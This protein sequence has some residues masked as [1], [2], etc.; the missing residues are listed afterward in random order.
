MIFVSFV[1]NIIYIQFFGHIMELDVSIK[2][3]KDKLAA[4]KKAE[5]RLAVLHHIIEDCEIE[6][7]IKRSKMDAEYRD[8]KKLEQMSTASLYHKILGDIGTTI[9]KEKQEYLLSVLQ[10]DDV[11]NKISILEYEKKI[12]QA[13]VHKKNDLKEE[14]DR[15]IQQKSLQISTEKNHLLFDAIKGMDDKIDVIKNLKKD[16]VEADV[17]AQKLTSYLQ[18]IYKGLSEIDPWYD[19]SANQQFTSYSRLQYAKGAR[20]IVSNI[21]RLA[22]QLNTELSDISKEL[23]IRYDLSPFEDFVQSIYKAAIDGWQSSRYLEKAKSCIKEYQNITIRMRTK[24]MD[25]DLEADRQIQIIESEK[26]LYIES[27]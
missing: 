8:V 18:D 10:F 21:D 15:L 4:V 11:A 22:Q 5:D 13:K 23:N 27:I 16:I 9:E 12:L 17:L 26:R 7:A 2:Q 3:V 6:L 24:L 19:W 25:M 14:L 1:T 20:Q